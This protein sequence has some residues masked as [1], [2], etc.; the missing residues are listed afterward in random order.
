[1]TLVVAVELLVE[2]HPSQATQSSGLPAGGSAAVAT[3]QVLSWHGAAPFGHRR[4]RARNTTGKHLR[5]EVR[6]APGPEN[7]HP[8]VVTGVKIIGDGDA[9]QL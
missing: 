9:N 3:L 7:S 2:V 1:M 5:P 8:I 4:P 6:S